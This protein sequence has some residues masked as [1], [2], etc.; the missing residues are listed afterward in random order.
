MDY[1]NLR[2]IVLKY[3]K[4]ILRFNWSIMKDEYDRLFEHIYTKDN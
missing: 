4:L 3:K 1:K 2:N